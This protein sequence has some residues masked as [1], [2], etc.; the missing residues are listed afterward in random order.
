MP[1]PFEQVRD[2]NSGPTSKQIHM[3]SDVDATSRSLH[4]TLG[5]G[6][7]QAFPGSRGKDLESLIADLQT[8]VGDLEALVNLI[9]SVGDTKFWPGAIVPTNWLVMDGS[10]FSGSTWPLLAAF[11]G[12][13]TLPDMRDR[14]PVGKSGTKALLSTGGADT[15]TMT[16]AELAHTHSIANVAGHT[17]SISNDG[18]HGHNFSGATIISNTQTG[19]T[20]DRMNGNGS[21]NNAGTHDHTG[22]TGSNGAHDHGAA[23]GAVSL[24]GPTAFSIQNPYLAGNWIIR[25]A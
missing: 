9:S 16:A 17:H 8:Q 15:H 19:G 7:N 24:S 12:G 14:G 23:T 21:T 11:L 22:A 3:D 2:R 18:S 6:N 10:A 13:T 5:D 4:H 20:A 1:N 25:A